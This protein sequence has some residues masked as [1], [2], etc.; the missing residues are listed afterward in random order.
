MRSG[1]GLSHTSRIK[2]RSSAGTAKWVA[3]PLPREWDGPMQT[4]DTSAYNAHNLAAYADVP[5]PE[6]L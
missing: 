2:E 1:C 4:A 3:V 6:G 5:R